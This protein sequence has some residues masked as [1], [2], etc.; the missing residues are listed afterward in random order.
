MPAECIAPVEGT[1]ARI[2]PL[3]SCGLAQL[4][5]QIVID[6]FVQVN[7][8]VAY[9]DGTEYR[10]RTASGVNRVN[11]RGADQFEGDD[12]SVSFCAIDPDAVVI[13]TGHQAIVTGSTGIGFW[14]K[15]GAISAHWS[16]ELW[17]ADADTCS[18]TTPR[19]AYWAWPHLHAARLTDMTLGDE[20]LTWEVMGRSEKG[21]TG[22]D[23][24]D[25]IMSPVLPAAGHRGFVITR[26]PPPAPTGCG[27]TAGFLLF[28]GG[29][30]DDLP[31]D[32]LIDAMLYDPALTD[33]IDAGDLL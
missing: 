4:D 13:T 20:V 12:V 31:I 6:G 5:R 29:Y 26:T 27:A 16:L 11:V 24:G 19:Y 14:V 28:D 25:D 18:G 21:Y 32:D 23:P 7:V 8:L 22:W 15:E 17:Q 1:R 9:E 30:I 10:S 33:V 2:T 3:D